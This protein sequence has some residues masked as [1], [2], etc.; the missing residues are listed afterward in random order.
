M[1]TARGATP[2]PSV[3]ER[4]RDP[5]PPCGRFAPTPSGP[6][7]FGSVVAALAS[8]LHTRSAGGRWL[9]RM[10]DLDPRRSYQATADH[11]LRTLERL[12][13]RWD[14]HVL[15]Q[16]RRSEAYAAALH[17][18]AS[19]GHVF[20][21]ACSRRDIALSARA[22]GREGPLYPGTCRGGPPNGRQ[23]RTLRLRVA[24]AE[25]CVEDRVQGRFCQNLA[26]EVGDFIVRRADGV[27]S[28]QLAVVVDDH[29]QGITQ[30]VRGSDLLASTPRQQFLRT[31]LALDD[32]LEYLHLPLAVARNKTKLSK[33][34]GARS[35][36]EAPAG[37]IV[38]AA[39][40]FLGQSP[41][42]EAAREPVETLLHWA[43]QC[44]NPARI[45]RR[46]DMPTHPYLALH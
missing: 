25:I 44:W 1:V 4:A 28:Y 23:P 31:L 38:H 2:C 12:G 20:E 14:G 9:V 11:I 27:A 8:F 26:R 34:A 17:R 39:L 32:R 30:I 33:R 37:V 46:L 10:E 3:S 36:A 19:D 24:D 40:R 21:C 16:S 41:P 6:L 13:L 15:Y 7:H 5:K 29:D 43:T 22:H 45:P 35:I 18:L 42:A